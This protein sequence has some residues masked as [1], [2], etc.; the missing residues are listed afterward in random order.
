M[1]RRGPW[2]PGSPRR[3]H[4]SL[5][6]A[7]LTLGLMLAAAVMLAAAG[8]DVQSIIGLLAAIGAAAGSAQLAL[9]K[10]VTID[11]RAQHID[12]R[13]ATI[14]RQT[15]G[16]M[17]ATIHTAVHA[18]IDEHAGRLADPP[19]AAKRAPR[20]TPRRPTPRPET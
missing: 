14:E 9:T 4:A 16:E 6:G 2:A 12:E 20:R 17:S 10:V 3:S 13:T 11:E 8:W 18:A 19:A 1:S 7:V 15:N 5:W